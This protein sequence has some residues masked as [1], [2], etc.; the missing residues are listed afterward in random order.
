MP[1]VVNHVAYRPLSSFSNA[2]IDIQKNSK[3]IQ[4]LAHNYILVN[5]DVY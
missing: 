4:E 3:H 5:G 1:P 2:Y